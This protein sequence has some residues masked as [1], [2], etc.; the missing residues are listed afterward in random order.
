MVSAALTSRDRAIIHAAW[1]LGYVTSDVLR[2]LVSPHIA[3]RTMRRRLSRLHL[4]GYLV[5]QRVVGATG[6]LYLYG[7]GR[8]ALPEGAPAPWRPG[9]AQI[10]H[11]LAVGDTLLALIR[12]AFGAGDVQVTGWHGEAEIRAWSAP[13]APIPDLRIEWRNDRQAGRWD[14]EVDRATES[15][16]AWRRKL[17]RY[18]ADPRAQPVLTVTTSADRA[19]GLARI[20]ADVGALVWTTTA[21]AVSA[22]PDPW[23]FDAVHRR[24]TTLVAATRALH[25]VPRG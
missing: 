2:T 18:L 9:L 5:Q 8:R 7:A 22:E 20:A 4:G 16:A 14:V 1:S 15:R 23:V 19:R 11:T 3:T 24:R 13:G 6:H 17:A 12:P 10:D 21:S 25:P